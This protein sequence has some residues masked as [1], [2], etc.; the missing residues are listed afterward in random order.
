M[1]RMIKQDGGYH[2]TY[3]AIHVHSMGHGQSNEGL[4]FLLDSDSLLKVSAQ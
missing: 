4:D 3:V 2:V 1:A